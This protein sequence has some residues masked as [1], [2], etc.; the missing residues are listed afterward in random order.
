[1]NDVLGVIPDGSPMMIWDDEVTLKWTDEE[2][3]MLAEM[4]GASI[5]IFSP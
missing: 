2:K 4:G 1:M 5:T 3:E